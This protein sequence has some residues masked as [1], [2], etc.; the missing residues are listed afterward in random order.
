MRFGQ[1]SA[2]NPA[3]NSAQCHSACRAQY[4]SSVDDAGSPGLLSGQPGA[5]ALPERGFLGRVIEVHG[6]TPS[7]R[8]A[9][10]RRWWPSSPSSAL[11]NNARR[12]YTCTKHS[13]VLP[14]PPC[15]WIAV[16]HTVRAARAQYAL[17]T[18]PASQRLVRRQRV[19][20]PR[21]VL[22]HADRA[23][24]A[25]PGPRPAGAAPPGTSRWRRRTAGAPWRTRTWCRAR[26]PSCR[27][28]RRR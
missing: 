8:R 10:A 24:H 16:S 6:R 1:V 19:D 20:R 12:R 15:T 3:S 14:I 22:R 26:L 27:R 7:R 28:G 5:D 25:A 18:A 2:K 23:L 4:S 9:S 17:A 21:R 13:Q 11:D